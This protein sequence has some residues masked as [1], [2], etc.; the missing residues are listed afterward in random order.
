MPETP[1]E[2][3]QRVWP[4][5]WRVVKLGFLQLP[6]L[7]LVVGGINMRVFRF[8]SREWVVETSL[9]GQYETIARGEHLASA[10]TRA[11][12]KVR[13]DVAA[14]ARAVGLEVSGG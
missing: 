7:W 6:G 1:L 8:S 2:T 4:G 10:L 3:A 14:M 5:E 9:S 13:A 12:D 11:R